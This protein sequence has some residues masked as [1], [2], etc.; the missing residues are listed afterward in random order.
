MLGA[1]EEASGKV[2]G[3][4]GFPSDEATLPESGP[5]SDPATTREIY[6]L[7]SYGCV[8]SLHTKQASRRGASIR[9]TPRGLCQKKVSAE[10][11]GLVFA[12]EDGEEDRFQRRVV[13]DDAHGS[14]PPPHD[15]ESLL[16]GIGGA[17]GLSQG[18]GWIE[19]AGEP[20]RHGRRAGIR[21]LVGHRQCSL[22]SQP[23]DC[24]LMMNSKATGTLRIAARGIGA[25]LPLRFRQTAEHIHSFA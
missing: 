17:F 19:A 5:K 7:R 15:S 4:R 2:V 6:G 18:R 13:L 11:L 21:L 1:T 23:S 14:G 8:R 24:M 9:A 16:D 20:A 22:H 25:L 10:I 3:K 12:S